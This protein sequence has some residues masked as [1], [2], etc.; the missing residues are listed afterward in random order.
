MA[1]QPSWLDL[2][3][4]RRVRA[5]LRL[6]VEVTG[7]HLEATPADLIDLSDHG[8][9]LRLVARVSIGTFLT[10]DVEEFTAFSGWVAWSRGQEIGLDFAHPAPKEVTQH[11]LQ[12]GA[13][14]KAE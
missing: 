8:C 2:E 14:K 5:P 3:E 9:R 1:T 13:K 6:S 7:T 4:R 11:L 12:L 10:V